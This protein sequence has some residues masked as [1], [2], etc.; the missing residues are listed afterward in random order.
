MTIFQKHEYRRMQDWGRRANIEG[1][2]QDVAFRERAK[3]RCKNT[4]Q[5]ERKLLE[6]QGIPSSMIDAYFR[7]KKK[8]AQRDGN[9]N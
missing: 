8:S 5:L 7:Q 9:P 6:E 2:A 3:N 4:E 1:A